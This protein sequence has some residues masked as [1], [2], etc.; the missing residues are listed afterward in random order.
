MDVFFV[1]YGNTARLRLHSDVKPV[2]NMGV[3]EL[4]IIAIPCSLRG[5]SVGTDWTDKETDKLH[6]MLDGQQFTVRAFQLSR[7]L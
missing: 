6:K 4:Q 1:D 2:V 5:V 7:F 3:T